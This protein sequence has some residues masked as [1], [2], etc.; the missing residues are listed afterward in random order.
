MIG[1]ST[2]RD[3][4]GYTLVELVTT[5]VII[6][7]LGSAAI[8][9]LFDYQAISE[10]GYV[11]EVASAIRYAQK[12]AIAS[13]CEV[14]ISIGVGSYVASQRST[15]NNCNAA[16]APWTTPVRRSDASTLS[17]TA[18]N[19]VVMAPAAVLVF[20]RNGQLAVNPP[21]FTAGIFTLTIDPFGGAVT[22]T[23]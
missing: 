11:D 2:F 9:R 12:I 14:S 3:S 16:A 1:H 15:L 8:P 7:I 4:R 6:G 21:V 20:D 23:P 22:V 5:V 18:R 19:D 13:R 10:R 17:G